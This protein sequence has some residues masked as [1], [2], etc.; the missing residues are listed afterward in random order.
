MTGYPEATFSNEA[1]KSLKSGPAAQNRHNPSQPD[2]RRAASSFV[3][4]RQFRTT[5]RTPGTVVPGLG[6][7]PCHFAEAIIRK[8]LSLPFFDSLQ[9]EAGDEFG[10]VTIGVIGR[11]SAAAWIPHPVLA[12]IC[13]RDKRVDFTDDDG[14]LFQLGACCETES[15]ER[16]L[17]R[18]VN[19][20]MRN[21]HE[22]SAGA[23]AGDIT[24]DVSVFLA[25]LR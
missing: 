5:R 14:V 12:E 17:G 6:R 22:R 24:F 19:A 4:L 7:A 9:N 2:K 11:R 8:I 13:R 23:S 20:V 18:R 15:K 10:P 21:S 25:D 1:V 3:N 16:A